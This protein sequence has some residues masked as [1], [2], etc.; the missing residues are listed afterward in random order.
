M[1]GCLSEVGNSLRLGGGSMSVLV[2]L[3]TLRLPLSRSGTGMIS[4]S[5]RFALAGGFGARRGG[6]TVVAMR[7]VVSLFVTFLMLIGRT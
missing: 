5:L 7:C 2:S 1:V 3:L 4:F 6:L